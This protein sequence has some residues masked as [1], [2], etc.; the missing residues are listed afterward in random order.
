VDPTSRLTFGKGFGPNVDVTF[1]QSLRDNTAQTWIVE[2]LPTR[3]VDVRF[4]DQR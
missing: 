4:V 3:Q 2:Y 1:S